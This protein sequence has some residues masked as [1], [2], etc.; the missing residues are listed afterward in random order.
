MEPGLTFEIR[1]WFYFLKELDLEPI[2]WFCFDVELEPKFLNFF[3][4]ELDLE[5]ISGLYLVW[6]LNQFFLKKIVTRT[7]S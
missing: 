3:L 7:G 4:K 2:S 6:D 1:N 5:P